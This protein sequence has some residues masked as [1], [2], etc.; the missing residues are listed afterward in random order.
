MERNSLGK[1]AWIETFFDPSH[2]HT[3]AITIPVLALFALG[4]R[5]SAG[6]YFGLAIIFALLTGSL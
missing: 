5:R 3:Y 1:G 4:L 2:Y 6:I